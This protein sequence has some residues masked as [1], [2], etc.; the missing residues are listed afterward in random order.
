M[1]DPIEHARRLAERYV[2]YLND[3]D[4]DA[5]SLIMA[6]DM[7]SHLRIGDIKGLHR[8]RAL[9]EGT[10]AA[11]PGII[12]H[13]HEL[14]CAPGRVVIRYYFDAVHRGAWLGVPPSHRMVHLEGIEL[15]H[16]E[17][18]RIVEIWNYA[19][20]MGLAAQLRAADPLA[21]RLED[22]S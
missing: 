6:E 7:T 14:V 18:D 1:K 9:M 19:D 17:G 22:P 15:L 4:M 12:W 20:V 8:F 21:L 3:R 2:D 10:Y 16:I 5:L 11:F 13:T